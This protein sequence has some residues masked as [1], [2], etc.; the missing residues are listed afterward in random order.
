MC[1]TILVSQAMP[2]N[3]K[4]KRVTGDHTYMHDCTIIIYCSKDSNFEILIVFQS[5]SSHLVMV[6]LSMAVPASND[7]SISQVFFSLN[8]TRPSHGLKNMGKPG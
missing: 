7:I 3:L 1:T 4:R 6:C 2:L 5:T 8:L